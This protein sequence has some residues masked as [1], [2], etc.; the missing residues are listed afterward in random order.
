MYADRNGLPYKPVYPSEFI[1][2]KTQKLITERQAALWQI[3]G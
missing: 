2:T 3:E 1:I